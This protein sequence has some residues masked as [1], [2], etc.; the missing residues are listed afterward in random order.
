MIKAAMIE[1]NKHREMSQLS[2]ISTSFVLK[3]LKAR[4][5]DVEDAVELY[6]NYMVCVAY[7]SAIL[8]R[9]YELQL[10]CLYLNME[11]TIS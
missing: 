1:I 7:D 5:F 9:G 10:H 11:G 4:D 2:P 8:D 3:F 6:H